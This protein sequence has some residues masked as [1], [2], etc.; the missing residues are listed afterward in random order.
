MAKLGEKKPSALLTPKTKSQETYS[1]FN[2]EKSIIMKSCIKKMQQ[3]IN[4]AT[5]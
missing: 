2:H 1:C 4:F 5:L 3:L